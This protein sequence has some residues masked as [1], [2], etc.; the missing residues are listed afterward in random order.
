MMCEN[1]RGICLLN[2]ACQV[3]SVIQP[4]VETSIGNYQCGFRPGKSTVG[5]L[6]SVRQLP[7]KMK[8][9]GVSTYYMFAGF[10]AT[11]DSID[12]AGLFKAMEE[13]H[14]PRKLRRLV[15][16]TLQTVRCRVKTFNGMQEDTIFPVLN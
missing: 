4:T 12:R 9:Y 15:E 3:F 16:L 8:E 11:Y 7:E 10:K 2:T 6:H 1:Y 5:H 14:I 13:S